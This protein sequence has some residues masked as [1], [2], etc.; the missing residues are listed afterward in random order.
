M[1]S[2]S[3]AIIVGVL[4]CVIGGVMLIPQPHQHGGTLGAVAEDVAAAWIT[5][6]VQQADGVCSRLSFSSVDRVERATYECDQ[7]WTSSD[8]RLTGVVSSQWSEDTYQMEES[9]I[10]VGID[11]RY[12]QNEDGSWACTSAYLAKGMTPDPAL[13]DPTFTCVGDGAYE[14]LTAVLVIEAHVGDQ[15]VGLIFSGDLPPAPGTPPTE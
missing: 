2:P 7:T 6:S 9:V 1:L 4:V 12:L 14:G 13:S 10:S 8:P 3:K 15:F 11:A 5:G